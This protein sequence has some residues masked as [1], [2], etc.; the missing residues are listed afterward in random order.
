MKFTI[1]TLFPEFFQSYLDMGILKRALEDEL[2]EVELVNIRDYSLDKHKKADDYPYGEGPG[3]VLMPQPSFDALEGRA[4]PRIHL[5]PRGSLL[6]QEKVRELAQ[7]EEIVLFCSHY[8]G[9]DQR[10]IDQAIDEEIS[11]GDYVLSGGEMAAMIL[12]DAVIRLLPGV[13]SG[14]SVEVESHEE[15]L[16][17]YHQYTRP[18]EFRG[19]H[20]PKILRSGHHENI[21]RYRLEES[22]RLTLKQRPDMIRKG[23]EK[24][25]YTEEM[26]N[27]IEKLREEEKNEL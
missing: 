23:I 16:L 9:L 2:F 3:M 5:S 19:M 7:H 18:A 22:I 17:E 12:M 4:H 25:C 6:T 13:I 27:L 20:V 24:G 26:I 10:V 8:E 15:G 21:R 11:I 14:D 1:L